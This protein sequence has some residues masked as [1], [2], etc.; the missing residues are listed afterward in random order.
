MAWLVVH[1][2]KKTHSLRL[3]WC[4]EKFFVIYLWD[5]V[6]HKGN[7]W[8]VLSLKRTANFP[9]ENGWL[10]YDG[11]LLGFGLISGAIAVSFRE[12]TKKKLETFCRQLIE[13]KL[14]QGH[15]F[16][17]EFHWRRG[18]VGILSNLFLLSS[19][20]LDVWERKMAIQFGHRFEKPEGLKGTSLSHQCFFCSKESF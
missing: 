7:C 6:V 19:G 12:G 10:E 13:S 16:W 1:L 9:P 18:R 15:H 11:I 17:D 5:E 8:D 20:C 3:K 2:P 14:L 4:E